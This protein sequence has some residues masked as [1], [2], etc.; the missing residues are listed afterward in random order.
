MLADVVGK[1][2]EL[3]TELEV[4]RALPSAFVPGQIHIHLA[5]LAGIMGREIGA[6]GDVKK[7]ARLLIDIRQRGAE[8]VDGTLAISGEICQGSNLGK[9]EVVV[10]LKVISISAGQHQA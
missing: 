3:I 10:I 4:V 5:G 7:T 1:M 9:A 2:V 8:G 6:V